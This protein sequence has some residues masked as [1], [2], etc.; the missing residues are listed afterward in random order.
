[1]P[2][3]KGEDSSGGNKEKKK[4]I[5]QLRKDHLLCGF[6]FSKSVCFIMSLKMWLF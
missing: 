5:F 2:E 3:K 6:Q 4:E 1:M